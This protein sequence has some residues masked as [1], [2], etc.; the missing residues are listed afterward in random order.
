MTT[1]KGWSSRIEEV[2]SFP[3]KAPWSVV[4]PI[5]ARSCENNPSLSDLRAWLWRYRLASWKAWLGGDLRACR[6]CGGIKPTPSRS[7]RLFCSDSC[8][9]SAHQASQ[10][11]REWPLHRVVREGQGELSALE[12]EAQQAVAWLQASPQIR[13]LPPDLASLDNLPP[14]P[15]RCQSGCAGRP[16]RWTQG[17]PCLYA[18]TAQ[19]T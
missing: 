12:V 8:R 18:N 7:D 16:C 4:W 14:L 2:A 11:E 17:G 3:V 15:D 9:V 6:Y 1:D 10:A 5:M 19:E 13:V